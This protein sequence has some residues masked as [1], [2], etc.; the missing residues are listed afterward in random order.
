MSSGALR[1]VRPRLDD[2]IVLGDRSTNASGPAVVGEMSTDEL[3]MDGLF[4]GEDNAAE[5]G[6]SEPER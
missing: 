2:N 3:D 6:I 1:H 4:H 5:N